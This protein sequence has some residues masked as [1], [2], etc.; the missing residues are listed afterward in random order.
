[1]SYALKIAN[2]LRL[3]KYAI[4]RTLDL[5][6]EGSSIPF[7]AR[8][9]KELTGSLDEVQIAAI[10]DAQNYFSELEKR[11]AAILSSLAEQGVLTKSLE[12]LIVRCESSA[13]LEDLYLP[14]KPKRKTRADLAKEG[15]LEP[16]AKIIWEQKQNI[17]PVLISNYLNEQWTSQED[18]LQGARDI[19]AEW[20]NEDSLIRSWLRANFERNAVIQSTVQ[21]K[22]ELEGIKFKDYFKFTERLSNIPSHRLLALFRGEAEG[23]L[24][25]TVEVD[26]EYFLNKVAQ[27]IIKTSG[28]SAEQIRLALEDSYRRLLHPTIETEMRKLY[29]ERADEDAIQV[30]CENLKQLL[31]AAP[32]GEK[33]ILAVDPGFRTGCKVACIDHSGRFMESAEI[34]PLAPRS[35]P[36]SAVQILNKLL[37]KYNIQAIGIGNG[38]GG[39]EAMNFFQ[40]YFSG[41]ALELYM[42]DESGA[43]IYSAG[44]LAREEFPELD[45]TIRGAISIARRLMDPLA[46]LV[47]IDPK[48]IGVGQY[49]HDVNQKKLKL[50]LERTITYCV[51]QVGVNL[52]TA[53]VYLLKYVSGLGQVLAE[54]IVEYRNHHGL[55]RRREDLK[56]VQRMGEKAFEQCAGFLRIRNSD[57]PLDNTGVHPERYALVQIMA[58][59]FN[60]S[61]E[62]LMVNR[63]LQSQL[64]PELFTDDKTG[65]PTIL[66]ILRELEKPGFDP[67]GS[68]Q[69]FHFANVHSMAD[70]TVGMTLPGIVKNITQFGVFVDIGIKESAFIHI[71]NLAEKFIKDPMSVVRVQQKIE[72]EVF[73][74]DLDRKRISCRFLKA[75][76]T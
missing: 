52:N 62:D 53:S 13:E 36:D 58:K 20:I 25:L 5:L 74:I 4:Q 8:Y 69:N 44:A 73:D 11:R 26:V 61:L 28:T 34:Y 59:H 3:D 47:K 63:K 43:S 19:I 45:L 17:H 67:R 49:Q 24:K 23:I 76:D 40:S 46:E 1:M 35:E 38:T 15:G 30:F 60:C 75:F 22:K 9:R 29:K 14:Y 50:A 55:F 27:R 51:N 31:M 71:S 70:L 57:H 16:L 32:L 65:I 68:A 54:N 12:E 6:K 21:K 66:D 33:N 18:V 48:S 41:T 39:R 42:V 7:I 56:N 64:N 2:Q 10:Q 72:L 37:L